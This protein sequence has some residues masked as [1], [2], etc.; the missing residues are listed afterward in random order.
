MEIVR[1]DQDDVEAIVANMSATDLDNLPFG[2]VNVDSDGKILQFNKAEGDIV[3]TDPKAVIGKNFFTE[4]AP[5]AAVPEFLGRFQE[6]VKSGALS[7]L[8][9]FEYDYGQSSVASAPKH[10]AK[11][12][13]KK[14]ISGDGT[15]WIFAKRL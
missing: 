3:G 5:C 10:R 9:E 14:A 7:T 11:I 8:F 12:H 1:F 15:F 4:V 6:G 13:M 2:A